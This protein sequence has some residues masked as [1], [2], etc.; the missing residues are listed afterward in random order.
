ALPASTRPDPCSAAERPTSTAVFLRWVLSSVV[1]RSYFASVRPAVPAT[2]GVAIDVPEIRLYLLP[3]SGHV[4]S[5]FVPGAASSTA[6]PYCE[7]DASDSSG[8]S[9]DTARHSEY[10][11]GYDTPRVPALP[12]AATTNAPL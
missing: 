12:A 9:A 8:S 4:E 7:Y 10:A 3:G 11:A 6:S 5:T 2:T 1:V